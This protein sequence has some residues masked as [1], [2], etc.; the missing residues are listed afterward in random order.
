MPPSAADIAAVK[1]MLDAQRRQIDRLE[2]GQRR[3]L[4]TSLEAARKDLLDRLTRLPLDRFTA[5]HYRTALAQV[6]SGLAE[7][8]RA[9]DGTLGAGAALSYE[10]AAAHLTEQIATFSERFTGT[11]RP[12]NWAAVASVNDAVLLD[13]YEASVR[14]YGAGLIG[15]VQQQMAVDLVGGRPWTEV[16]RAIAGGQQGGILLEDYYGIA[17]SV[18]HRQSRLERIQRTELSY[19][20][21][22]A[23]HEDLVRADAEDPGYQKTLVS[24]FDNRTGADSVFVNG[25]VRDLGKPFQDNQGRE[26]QHPP[27]R[28]NDR[29]VE[30]PWRKEWGSMGL[31][32]S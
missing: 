6:L 29:E 14:T 30:I 2:M 27:N 17:A 25:Q 10:L 31:A 5:Q 7:V 19:A 1:R 15:R 13:R 24:T 12:N 28:P 8:T 11:V 32:V 26:Y 3:A 9:V 4:R 22:R 23:H 20:Y 21:N 16:A 18:S